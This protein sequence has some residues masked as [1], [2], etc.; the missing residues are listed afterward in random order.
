LKLAKR[1]EEVGERLYFDDEIP[2]PVV[3]LLEN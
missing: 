1:R 2:Q 3:E